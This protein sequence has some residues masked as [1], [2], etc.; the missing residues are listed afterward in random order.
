MQFNL[1]SQLGK[2]ELSMIYNCHVKQ[3]VGSCAESKNYVKLEAQGN[4]ENVGKQLWRK[5]DLTRASKSL[6]GSRY[7]LV[8]VR[9]HKRF[10]S[11]KMLGPSKCREGKHGLGAFAGGFLIISFLVQQQKNV[12]DVSL[13]SLL[14]QDIKQY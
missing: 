14:K 4:G 10:G 12:H 9:V 1:Q 5:R 8:E 2:T 13:S 6:I 7:G 3:K 11:T